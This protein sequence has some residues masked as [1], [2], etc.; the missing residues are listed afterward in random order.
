V[1]LAGTLFAVV[2]SRPTVLIVTA[3]VTNAL[4]L[5]VI[6]LVLVVLANSRLMPQPFRNGRTGNLLAIAVLA[7][8]LLLALTKLAKLL[9]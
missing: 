8:V 9:A 1:L 2:T 4:L 6:A 5:P 7:I 3:Q